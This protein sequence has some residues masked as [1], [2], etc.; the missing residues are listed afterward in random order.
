MSQVRD[1]VQRYN[2]F[3]AVFKPKLMLKEGEHKVL[4]KSRSYGDCL[5]FKAKWDKENNFINTFMVTDIED[6]IDKAFYVHGGEIYYKVNTP[7]YLIGDKLKGSYTPYGYKETRLSKG[8][9]CLYHRL[10]WRIAYG[11]Y[12]KGDIDHI[13]GVRDDNRL[14]NLRDVSSYENSRNKAIRRENTTGVSGV[15]YINSLGK[16]RSVIV[17]QDGDRVY[18]YFGYD[19]FEA[20]CKRKSAEIRFGYHENHSRRENVYS[21]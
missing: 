21:R 2:K 4:F 10:V 6:Y 18:L 15:W 11:E 16:F 8:Y 9:S 5:K 17:N 14:E 12:P 19:F 3:F 20:V 1:G 7:K 13:N